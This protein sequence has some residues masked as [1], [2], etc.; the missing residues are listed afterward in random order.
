MTLDPGTGPQ[1]RPL[2]VGERVDAAVKLYRSS[3][4]R[5]L[6]ALSAVA[7]LVAAID[8]ALQWWR[9][10]TIVGAPV[11]IVRNTLTN[12]TIVHWNVVDQ[13]FGTLVFTEIVAL[14][15][16][17]PPR[18]IAYRFYAD[19]YL[20]RQATPS[21][22]RSAG[23]RRT[24]SVLWVVF[25]IYLVFI[26]GW[27][28]IFGL[29]AAAASGGHGSGALIGLALLAFAIFGTWWAIA[30]RLAVPCVMLEG[31]RGWAALRRSRQLVKGSWWSVFWTIVLAWLLVI[32]ASIV[33]NLVGNLLAGIAIRSSDVG[34]HAFVVS[35]IAQLLNL[36]LIVPFLCSVATVVTVDM[37][38]R[39]EGLDLSL[40]VA[41]AGGAPGGT[42]PSE[43]PFGQLPPP[44]PSGAPQWPLPP[45]AGPTDPTS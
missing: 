33:F 38:V 5:L 37:R 7:L 13:V 17:V 12:Q 30:N 1:L 22:I 27:G 20:D 24:G 40:L 18:A 28:L 34:P 8:A 44:P 35:L 23:L 32:V 29:A 15:L 42:P 10:D 39:K 31:L 16:A 9:A 19:A 36:F 41:G 14:L 11:F 3:L 4:R 21:E 26:A 43:P 45:P 6:P 25:L 2:G